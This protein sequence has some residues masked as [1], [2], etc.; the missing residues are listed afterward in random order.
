[1]DA[2]A[3]MSAGSPTTTFSLSASPAFFATSAPGSIVGNYDNGL[4]AASLAHMFAN[5]V[6][7]TAGFQWQPNADG[8]SQF[9]AEL[10]LG[11]A[12]NFFEDEDDF[13]ELDSNGNVTTVMGNLLVGVPLGKVRPYGTVG[14]GL[15][16]ADLG[17]LDF[18]DDLSRNDLGVNYGGGVMVF[19]SDRIAVRGDLR[20]F[21]SLDNTDLDDDFPEPRDFR[22]G[23]FKFWRATAGV[24][25]RF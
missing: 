12:P 3:A 23:D 2:D 19:V 17:L 21:R 11:Y 18:F 15:M 7:A 9:Y 25:F 6:I 5:G 10:D 20:Q 24:T 16:R 4:L 13:G 22:L 1:M 8:S 14:L